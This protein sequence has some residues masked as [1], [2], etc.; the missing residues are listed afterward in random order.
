MSC[1]S[2]GTGLEADRST[3][4]PLLADGRFIVL[5]RVQDGAPGG[6]HPQSPRTEITSMIPHLGARPSGSPHILR[7]RRPVVKGVRRR[8]FTGEYGPMQLRN[9]DPHRHAAI[10]CDQQELAARC[11]LEEASLRRRQAERT[12]HSCCFRSTVTA[13]EDHRAIRRDHA[14]DLPLNWEADNSTSPLR[15]GDGINQP[16]N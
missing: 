12:L 7:V 4:F 14:T 16:P 11:A 6:L 3:V 2:S 9:L 5:R 15:F 10:A 1:E 8:R 13:E